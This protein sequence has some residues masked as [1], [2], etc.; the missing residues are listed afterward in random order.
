MNVMFAGVAERKKEIGVMM[1][2]GARKRDI[3]NQ[4][5][6]ESVVLTIVAGFIGVVL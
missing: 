1:A 5:I 3:L 6:I 2:I 4:I